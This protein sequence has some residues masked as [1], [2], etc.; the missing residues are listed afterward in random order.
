MTGLLYDPN[1]LSAALSEAGLDALVATTAANVRYLT[2][3]GKPGRSVAVVR[4]DD[5][6]R[7]VLLTP[8]AE[9]DYLIEDLAPGLAHHAWGDFFREEA[10]GAHLDEAQLLVASAHR[11]RRPELDRTA[12]IARTAADLD[13]QRAKIGMDVAPA[14]EPA[15]TAALR[16]HEVCDATAVLPRLRMRKTELEVSRLQEAA[17]IAESAILATVAI[18]APGI[19]Q[20]ELATEYRVAVAREGGLLRVDS[21]SVGTATVFGNANLP[22]SALAPGDIL[23]FDVG[24]IYGGY[25]S[26]LSRCFGLGETSEK[27]RS[28]AN[29]V[30]AGQS[31][32]LEMLRPGVRTADVFAAAVAE[33]RRAGIPH[34]DRTH[35]GHGIGLVGGYDAP[36]LAPGDPHVIEEGMVLCVETP[37]YEFGFGGVQIEDMVVVTDAGWRALSQLPRTFETL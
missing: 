6:A 3:F 28:Y 19:T 27:S 18:A 31:A 17:R 20:A 26:D 5:P 15:V 23:R 4:R 29:A 22:G 24:A 37:Y 9:L 21:V 12:M 33:T 32:A 25:Q 35:V 2:R 1:R 14:N 13:L 11:N 36:L 10:T 30:I 34:Y 16:D 7:P 8:A